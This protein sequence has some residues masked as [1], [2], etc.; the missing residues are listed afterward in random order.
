M[1]K[2]H[3]CAIKFDI[4]ISQ[5]AFKLLCMIDIDQYV[6]QDIPYKLKGPFLVAE[7]TADEY[8]QA[9]KIDDLNLARKQLWIAAEE[10][11]RAHIWIENDYT[12]CSGFMKLLDS[13]RYCDEEDGLKMQLQLSTSG[14]RWLSF[15]KAWIYGRHSIPG[16]TKLVYTNEDFEPPLPF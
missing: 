12:T 2:R 8:A 5:L 6:E 9:M 7:I 11:L 10:L 15:E 14:K 16:F 1:M 4:E 3:K 13:F